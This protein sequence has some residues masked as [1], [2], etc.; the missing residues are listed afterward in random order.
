MG[1]CCSKSAPESERIIQEKLI[2][3]KKKHIKNKK[4]I[5]TWSGWF[6]KEYIF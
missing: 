5:I 3:G 2:K 4:I 6:W 1:G